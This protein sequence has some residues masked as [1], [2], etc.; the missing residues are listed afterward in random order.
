MTP[1]EK[2]MRNYYFDGKGGYDTWMSFQEFMTGPGIDLWYKH[3]GKKDGGRVDMWMGG[4]LGLGKALLRKIMQHHAE[5]GETGLKG[6]EM[7]KL[8]NPKSLNNLLN[9]AK[10]IPAIARELI[11]KHMK[12]MKVDQIDAVDHSL[13]MAKDIKK[14]KDKVKEM[15]ILTEGITK[16]MVDK[17]MDKKIVENLTDMFLNAKYPDYR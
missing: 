15:D 9:T 13:K 4:K 2:W 5:R 11:E 14:S 1:S 12:Q 16:E 3:I 10:G 6:S 8:V 7:L 17:G